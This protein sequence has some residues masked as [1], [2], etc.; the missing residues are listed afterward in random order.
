MGGLTLMMIPVLERLANRIHG[1]AIVKSENAGS[2]NRSD[3]TFSEDVLDAGQGF[4]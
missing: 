1:C 4:A 3:I 2:A